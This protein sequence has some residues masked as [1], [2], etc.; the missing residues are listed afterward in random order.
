VA[1]EWLVLAAVI[2]VAAGARLFDLATRGMWDSDQGHDMLVLLALVRDGSLPLLGPPTSI[3]DFHHGALYYYIL[4][5]AAF[6]SGADPVAVT[7]T[8]AIAGLLA[9]VVV[10]WLAR[11]IGGPI[12]GLVAGILMAVSAT[13]IEGST[14]I[15]NPNILPLFSAIAVGCAWQ[16]YATRRPPWWLGAAGGLAVAMQGHVLATILLL[17]LVALFVADAR[18][19]SAHE[20]GPLLRIG[21]GCVLLVLVAYVPLLVHELGHGFSETRAAIAFLTGAGPAPSDGGGQNVAVRLVVIAVRVLSWPL[22]GLLTAAPVPAVLTATAIVLISVLLVRYGRGAERTAVL[23]LSATLVWSVVVLAIVAP[24]LATVVPGLPNDHY[25]A[26]LDPIV[27]VLA[28]L[29]MAGL[30]RQPRYRIAV[31]ALVVPV[32]LFNVA[33]WPPAT[34][35]DGGYPAADAAARRV[36]ADAGSDRVLLVGVPEFKP[37][38]AYGYPLTRL[39]RPPEAVTD[40]MGPFAGMSLVISCDRL[41]EDVTGRACGGLAEDE[42]AAAID[43]SWQLVDRFDAPPRTSISVYRWH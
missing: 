1:S 12:A 42:T 28:G 27:F 37:T 8:I 16:A 29:G 23:W 34:A 5:P 10:W 6:L 15:W 17:P 41:F 30:A 14:F 2:A 40:L 19:R 4:A 31:V 18:R 24:S 21:L 39:G 43:A 20:R 11:S 22:T 33:T 38:D 9:V 7:A 32:L 36:I 25:H 3:G 13:S 35:P 26:F